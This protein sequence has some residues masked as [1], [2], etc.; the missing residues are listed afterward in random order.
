MLS[1]AFFLLVIQQNRKNKGKIDGFARYE[2][3]E[4]DVV[5]LNIGSCVDFY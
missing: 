5:L 2:R 4:Q 1:K 3:E